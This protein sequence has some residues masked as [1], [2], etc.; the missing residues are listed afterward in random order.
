MHVRFLER[1]FIIWD[2]ESPEK[3]KVSKIKRDILDRA[4]LRGL[5]LVRLNKI[6]LLIQSHLVTNPILVKLL[7]FVQ[8]GVLGINRV[9]LIHNFL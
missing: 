7:F 3:K 1:E 4:F 2:D 5:S 8:I 6:R 9:S